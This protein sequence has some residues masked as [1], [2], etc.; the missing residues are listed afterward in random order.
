MTF[1]GT[2]HVPGSK[3]MTHRALILASRSKTPCEVVNGLD[4]LDTA[5]T[6]AGLGQANVDCHNSGTTLRLLTGQAATGTRPVQ[7][8][9]DAS[10]STRPNGPLLDALGAAGCTIEGGPTLPFS[11]QG[12]AKAGLFELPAETS[13]QFGSAILLAAP[14]LDG[15]STLSMATPVASSPYLDITVQMMQ[16]A[17]LDVTRDGN[18][19]QIPGNQSFSAHQLHVEGDWSTAAFPA[20]AA[21]ITQG[22]VSLEGLRLDSVQGDRRVLHIL[23]AFGAN[24]EGTTIHGASLESPGTVDVSQMPDA[25]PALAI[26]AACA[27]GT[28]T[29][30]GGAA[31]RHKESDRIKAMVRGLQAMGCQATETAEGAIIEGGPL[32]GS[33]IQ[34]EGDHR[35]HMAFRVASLVAKGLTTIDHPECVAVSYPDFYADLARCT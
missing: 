27:R 26:L 17:G 6:A 25:F 3:S 20:V 12:P 32:E 18:Q 16:G 34:C 9:G 21:C 10:L 19:F 22:R 4:S 1:D 13:S 30:V 11:V 31:L 15:D 33:N 2:V 29:F 28:T 35:I 14:F 24:V 23:S 5:A 7:F 8:T